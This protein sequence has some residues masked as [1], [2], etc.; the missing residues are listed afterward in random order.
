M[1]HIYSIRDIEEELGVSKHRLDYA[2]H[3]LKVCKASYFFLGRRV[4][5]EQAVEKLRQHFKRVREMEDLRRQQA[6]I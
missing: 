3:G 2:I 1:G 6:G 4:F 5:D